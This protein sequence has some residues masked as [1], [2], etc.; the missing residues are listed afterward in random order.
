[1]L[2]EQFGQ[3]SSRGVESACW[4]ELLVRIKQ[5]LEPMRLPYLGFRAVD[6]RSILGRVHHCLNKPALLLKGKH[7]KC[8][9]ILLIPP[10]VQD[11]RVLKPNKPARLSFRGG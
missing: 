3:F 2:G 9:S 4:F 1:M 6:S 8:L 11:L 7:S 5:Q 10:M